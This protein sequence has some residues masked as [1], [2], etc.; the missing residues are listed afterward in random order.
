MKKIK[1]NDLKTKYSLIDI[2]FAFLLICFTYVTLCYVLATASI[3]PWQDWV[4]MRWVVD[5][6]MNWPFSFGDFWKVENGVFKSPFMFMVTCFNIMFFHWDHRLECCF[7]IFFKSATAICLYSWSRSHLDERRMESWLF[8]VVLL[9]LV[10]NLSQFD[11]YLLSAGAYSFAVCSLVVILYSQMCS[12]LLTNSRYKL[13]LFC[14]WLTLNTMIV[15]SSYT[16][17]ALLAIPPTVTYIIISSRK[18][19]HLHQI[20]SVGFIIAVFSIIFLVIYL[21]IP[22]LSPN[23][24]SFQD[25]DW[26][27][28]LGFAAALISGGIFHGERVSVTT[29][30]LSGLLLTLLYII[31]LV[32]GAAKG[33]ISFYK[34]LPVSLI[35]F[36]IMNAG[37]IAIG[38]WDFGL[39]TALSGRYTTFQVL[40]IMGP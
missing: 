40:G 39:Q 1:K 15:S 25:I 32:H 21:K 18:V 36:A 7:Y 33:I 38:R 27:K 28:L 6:S 5:S 34:A 37:I 13:L 30:I 17:S 16:I 29:A 2:T 31:T 14:F 9:C 19:I 12:A 4:R 3:T 24:Q 35:L 20:R 26:V 10:F 22:S 23:V 8:P 11:N